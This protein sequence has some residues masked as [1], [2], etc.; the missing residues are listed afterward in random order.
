MP[1]RCTYGRLERGYAGDV[2]KGEQGGRTGERGQ[3]RRGASPVGLLCASGR[4]W[5]RSERQLIQPAGAV[6]RA[7]QF[8]CEDPT[9]ADNEYFHV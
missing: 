9:A 6:T 3:R 4:G 7:P 5:Q 2:G 8:E 1:D